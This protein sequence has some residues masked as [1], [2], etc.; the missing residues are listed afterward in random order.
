MDEMSKIKYLTQALLE[1]PLG[2][3]WS[4]QGLGMLR[5]YLDPN[6]KLRLH[7]WTTDHAA[8]VKPSELHTHPWDFNS[9]VIA[10]I[11]HN[12]RYVGMSDA[13][14]IEDPYQQWQRQTIRC[15]VGGGLVG[16]P[17]IVVLEERPIETYGAGDI[18][19]QQA[20]EIHKSTPRDGTVTIIDR[21]F[22]D[23][24]D[25]A[26]VYFPVGEDWVTAEPRPA[27]EDEIL[28]ICKNSLN[29]WF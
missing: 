23:D 13:Q 1:D 18:Y 19:G 2:R 22:S 7:V 29:L 15:G 27:T 11:V 17:E 6:H 5:T 21:V 3:E 24:A 28:K 14:P 4:I 20:I 26:Y 9:Q 25:H 10:G 16:T 12:R 8:D